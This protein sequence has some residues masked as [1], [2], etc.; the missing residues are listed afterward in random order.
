MADHCDFTVA[1]PGGEAQDLASVFQPLGEV[2]G[3][4]DPGAA[5]GFYSWSGLLGSIRDGC[6]TARDREC[7]ADT[8]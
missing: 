6:R 5:R 7:G 3:I 1:S 2:V 8:R 4:R